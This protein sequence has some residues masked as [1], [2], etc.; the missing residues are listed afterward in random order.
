MQASYSRYEQ[1]GMKSVASLDQTFLTRVV[2]L[3]E[4]H[5][6]DSECSI[7]DLVRAVGISR[8]AFFK[9]IKSLTGMSPI[10]LIRDIRIQNAARLLKTRQ[11]MVK[12]VACLVGFTDLKYFTQC[13]KARYKMTPTQYKDSHRVA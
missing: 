5:L 8:T 7:E 4:Q 3:L 2:E 11:L 6:D 13:F 12:E 1:I 10:E 9:K